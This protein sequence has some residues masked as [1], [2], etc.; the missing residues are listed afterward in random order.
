MAHYQQQERSHVSPRKHSPPPQPTEKNGI[1]VHKNT[2]L[3]TT[4]TVMGTKFTDRF[5]KSRVVAKTKVQVWRPTLYEVVV[6]RGP[7][8]VTLCQCT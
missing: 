1:R 7:K 6:S 4:I 8:Y 2:N 5:Q 3:I